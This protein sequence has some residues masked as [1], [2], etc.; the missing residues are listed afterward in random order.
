MD[1]YGTHNYVIFRT[2]NYEENV[3]KK[4]KKYWK[5]TILQKKLPNLTYVEKNSNILSQTQNIAFI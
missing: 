2:F 4:S 3:R 5:L 1:S